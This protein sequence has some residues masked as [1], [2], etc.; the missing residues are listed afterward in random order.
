MIHALGQPHQR[1][2]V[3]RFHRPCRDLRDQSHVLSR[4]QAGNQVVE[5]KH[6]SHVIT[7]II[8]EAGIVR[9]R[10]VVVEKTGDAG[11]GGVQ[12]AH[13]VQQSR[14][15]GARRTKQ[16]HQLALEE[17]QIY[18]AQRV[19]RH[20]AGVIDLGEPA[21]LKGDRHAFPV[22]GCAA[23]CRNAIKARCP[24]GDNPHFPQGPGTDRPC[25][26]SSAWI[27]TPG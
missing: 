16:H 19:H 26:R 18:P 22:V 2:S 23:R 20:I 27:G 4:G 13:D 25:I 7:T 9:R 3:S 14:L 21:S 8:G 24:P 6:E 1:Q 5:L 15:A 17:V 11:R 12:A 10:E